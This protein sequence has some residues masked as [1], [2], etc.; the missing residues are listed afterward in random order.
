MSLIISKENLKEVILLAEGPEL[1]NIS[2]YSIIVALSWG[3]ILYGLVLV[4]SI[5]G[6]IEG[7]TLEYAK[8]IRTPAMIFGISALISGALV[9]YLP[10][11]AKLS[12]NKGW[13]KKIILAAIGGLPVIIALSYAFRAI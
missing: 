1:K 9:G 13:I 11:K 2:Y 3:M 12:D 5:S 7:A 6:K 4:F 8:S 10:S